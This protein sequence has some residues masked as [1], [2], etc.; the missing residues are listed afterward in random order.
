M[1]IDGA[2]RGKF[3]ANHGKFAP[4][5]GNYGAFR[6]KFV[7]NH[8]NYGANRGKFPPNRGNFVAN[9]G[10][11]GAFR[12]RFFLKW[13]RLTGDGLVILVVSRSLAAV[14]FAFFSSFCVPVHLC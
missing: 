8:G 14:V 2:S 10:R 6:G 5:R 11:F 13:H 4:N 9:P 1:T 12:G 3:V 7:A